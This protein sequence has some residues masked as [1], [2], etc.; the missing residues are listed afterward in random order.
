LWQERV[1]AA[2]EIADTA[3]PV[4]REL[5]RAVT[6]FTGRDEELAAVCGRLAAVVQALD[7]ATGSDASIVSAAVKGAGT[8]GAG[9]ASRAS[10]AGAPSGKNRAA[11]ICA[12]D[13]MGGVGKS[14]LVIQ[15]ANMCAD[16]FPDGQLYVNLRGATPGLSPLDALGHIMAVRRSF[17]I[18]LHALQDSPETVDNAAYCLMPLAPLP[19]ARICPREDAMPTLGGVRETRQCMTVLR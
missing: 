3:R 5:P 14:A 16:S 8:S 1:A 6:D 18:S 11:A 19:P 10:P 17:D 12:V 2:L 15:A 7:A 4:P 9:V 13:G